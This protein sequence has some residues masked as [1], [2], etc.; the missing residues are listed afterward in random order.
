MKITVLGAGAMGSLFS[1]YLSRK[2]DVTVVD[3]CDDMVNAINSNG[4]R[5]RERDGSVLICHPHAVKSTKGIGFQDL[6]IVFVKSMFTISALEG[7]RGLIGPMMTCF[8]SA[9]LRSLLS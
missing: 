2:N 1:G 6:I 9:N 3:V 5:I 7:N 8:L 4:A